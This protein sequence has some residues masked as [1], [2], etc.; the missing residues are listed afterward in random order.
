[1]EIPEIGF[2]TYRLTKVNNK[3]YEC[4]LNALKCGYR[5]IDTASLYCNEKEVQKAIRD[6]EIN[7]SAIFLTTKIWVKNIKNINKFKK[8]LEKCLEIFDKIDLLLLHTEH[9]DVKMTL[10]M[11]EYLVEFQKIKQDKIYKIGVSNF[12]IDTLEKIT[13]NLPHCNQIEISPYFSNDNL[14]TYC[15]QKGIK[16]VAHSISSMGNIS[17]DRHLLQLAKKYNVS[18]F[19]L[20]ISWLLSKNIGVLVSTKNKE[21]LKENLKSL[22]IR[23]EDIFLIDSLDKH[24]SF[25]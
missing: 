20:V 2:G 1:M 6:S 4:V 18:L 16:V 9:K 13:T 15:R 17:E 8:Q 12:S 14:V 24:M 3:A 5:H 7:I 19:Q 25:Y 10:D 11:W 23:N 22:K 21:H